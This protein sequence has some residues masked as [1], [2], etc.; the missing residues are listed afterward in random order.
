MCVCALRSLSRYDLSMEVTGLNDDQS[1]DRLSSGVRAAKEREEQERRQLGETEL[2]WFEEWE[3]G[4]CELVC[5][6][7]RGASERQAGS[8][9]IIA[10][11]P[12]LQTQAFLFPGNFVLPESMVWACCF[13]GFFSLSVF[14]IC[15]LNCLFSACC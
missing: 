13:H 8:L 6:G 9:V 14:L 3:A 7:Y 11:S 4:P 12:G 10:S 2:S 1:P 5:R 15:D